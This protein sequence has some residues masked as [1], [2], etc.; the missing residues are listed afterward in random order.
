MNADQAL[1]SKAIENVRALYDA[2][3]AG[4][5]DTLMDLCADGFRLHHPNYPEPVDIEGLWRHV[6]AAS[7]ALSNAKHI[8][9]DIVAS[10]RGVTVRGIVTGKH[11]GEMH[12]V[13]AS[14]NEIHVDWMSISS[15]DG[16]GRITDMWVQ[17]DQIAF[18]QQIGAM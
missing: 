9:M 1:I 3:D 8:F 14:N 6:S 7:A 13:P 4:D 10:D 12:G 16:D 18:L 11:T 17:F 2:M 5:K 15:F